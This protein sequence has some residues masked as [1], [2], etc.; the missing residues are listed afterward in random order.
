M[1][2]S[3]GDVKG[4]HEPFPGIERAGGQQPLSASP[5]LDFGQ[6]QSLFVQG[7]IKPLL[8]NNMDWGRTSMYSLSVV[9]LETLK[10][11]ILSR[12]ARLEYCHYGELKIFV[13]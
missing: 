11:Q 12:G 3:R 1:A 8:G 13:V 9:E 5:T 10:N 7:G 4:D 6:L 2:C